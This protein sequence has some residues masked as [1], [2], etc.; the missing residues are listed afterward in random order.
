MRFISA[1]AGMTRRSAISGY[2]LRLKQAPS[3]EDIEKIN[4][5]IIKFRKIQFHNNLIF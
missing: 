5:K 3:R 2:W 4:N 1:C